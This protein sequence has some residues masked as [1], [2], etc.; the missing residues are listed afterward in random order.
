[1]RGTLL[2]LAE[3]P[4]LWI[5]LIPPSDVIVGDGYCMVTSLRSATV[6][7]VRLADDS[8]E[9]AVGEVRAQGRALGL[10]HVT[11]WTG[12]RT[13]PADAP[14]RLAALGLEPDPDQ[15]ELTSLT[16]DREPAGTPTVEVRRAETLDDYLQALELDWAVWDVPQEE[17]A[18]QRARHR[19]H[20]PAIAADRRSSHYLAYV[21]GVPVGFGRAAFT[22]H[23]ALLLG[24]V[25]L[26]HARGR[27]AYLALVHA[28]WREAVE[29]GTPRVTVSGGPMSAP[30]LERLGF[31]PMGRL[32]LLRDR[33]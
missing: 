22:P 8:V 15:P 13:T 11:W 14:V 10:E 25:V 16:I 4:G 17:R 32:R 27:G 3:E 28:R 21:D 6:E 5:P 26:P 23:G 18:G 20:W 29:R 30:I 9:W 24:G 2:E 31:E 12:E 33:L 7:R 1:M 19:E